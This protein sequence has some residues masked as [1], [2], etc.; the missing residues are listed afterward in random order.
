MS[1]LGLVPSAS[2]SQNHVSAFVNKVPQTCHFRSIRNAFTRRQDERLGHSRTRLKRRRSFEEGTL[3]EHD[4]PFCTRHQ[5]RT[6]QRA[7]NAL[8]PALSSPFLA[9]A[10]APSALD[11]SRRWLARP[12]AR[13]QNSNPSRAFERCKPQSHP[14]R[15]RARR[16]SRAIESP[17]SRES[18]EHPC[19]DS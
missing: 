19:S 7:R 9:T 1:F 2:A 10:P 11:M 16:S 13:V 18:T 12:S 6:T 5:E 17:L 14:D 8:P 4:R 15:A 3:R